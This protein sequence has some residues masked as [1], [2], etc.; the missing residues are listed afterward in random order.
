MFNV[1]LLTTP[2]VVT[3]NMYVIFY[4]KTVDLLDSFLK[5]FAKRSALIWVIMQRVGVF[6]YRRSGKTYQS[7][8]I[9]EP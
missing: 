9:L 7:K 4:L 6:S 3:W 2:Y 5:H 8:R 1:D